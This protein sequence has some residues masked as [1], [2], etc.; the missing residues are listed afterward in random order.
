MP[1]RASVVPKH[2]PCPYVQ[3]T[4]PKLSPALL[5]ISLCLFSK[6][7]SEIPGCLPIVWPNLPLLAF[8]FPLGLKLYLLFVLV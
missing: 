2:R 5:S 6:M 3:M 4:H 8:S 7:A 1:T